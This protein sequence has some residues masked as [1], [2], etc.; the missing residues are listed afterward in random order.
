MDM[1]CGNGY[2]VWVVGNG[3]KFKSHDMSASI[4][5]K[6]D[7]LFLLLF[8]LPS[9]HHSCEIQSYRVSTEQ[10][11]HLTGIH[12]SF[13][14]RFVRLT[15]QACARLNKI[16]NVHFL[17][18]PALRSEAVALIQVRLFPLWIPSEVRPPIQTP[19]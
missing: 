12:S 7:I 19:L 5:N 13:F 4:L 10:G 16:F 14:S 1:R 11:V 6:N 3:S 17:P 9:K 15:P 2:A 8:V 18:L